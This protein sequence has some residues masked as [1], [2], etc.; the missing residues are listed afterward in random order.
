MQLAEKRGIKPGFG[1]S[2]DCGHQVQ[3]VNLRKML[4]SRLK[5]GLFYSSRN[6]TKYEV[7]FD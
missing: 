4:L 7:I 1:I 5:T 3:D 2:D 6:E